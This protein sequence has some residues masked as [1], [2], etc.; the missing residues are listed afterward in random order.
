MEELKPCPFCG[1][2]ATFASDNGRHGEVFSVWHI[3]PNVGGRFNKY[4]STE[5]TRIDT[6]WHDSEELAI[7]EWNRRAIDL[8]ELLKIADE[9]YNLTKYCPIE[10]SMFVLCSTLRDK[11]DRIRKA[12]GV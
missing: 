11:A 3:C 2:K 7:N 1:E 4:G 10:E 5:S 9:I 8:D 12:L 6:G